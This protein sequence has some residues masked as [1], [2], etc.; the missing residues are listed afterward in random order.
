MPVGN[1]C[2][3]SKSC[4]EARHWVDDSERITKLANVWRASKGAKLERMAQFGLKNS[5]L[6]PTQGAEVMGGVTQNAA[7]S[8]PHSWQVPSWTLLLLLYHLNFK[9]KFK[10][11][12]TLSGSWNYLEIAKRTEIP[13]ECMYMLILRYSPNP[14]Y[15]FKGG[16]QTTLTQSLWTQILRSE[17]RNSVSKQGLWC[18]C[19]WMITFPSPLLHLPHWPGFSTRL[20]ASWTG[21]MNCS[22]VISQVQEK[23][24]N[25]LKQIIS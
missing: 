4:S 20:L 1:G 16:P 8:S 19:L 15:N 7:V 12:L 13:E 6:L 17:V 24:P 5:L 10:W 22:A 3:W 11:Y 14:A 21:T 23:Q 25:S 2:A 18:E 9:Q